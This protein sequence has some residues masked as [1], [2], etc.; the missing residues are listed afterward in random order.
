[1][2]GSALGLAGA[3]RPVTV[4]RVAAWTSQLAA[5]GIALAPVSALVEAPRKPDS[6]R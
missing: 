1:E 5:Q 6:P 3:V 2:R 4:E